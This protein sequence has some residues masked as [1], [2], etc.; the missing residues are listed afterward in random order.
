MTNS[1]LKD[2]G[3][4][5]SQRFTELRL[6][7]TQ[8][9]SIEFDGCTFKGCDFTETH[10]D[11]CKFIDC[12]FVQCNFSNS[13]LGYSRFSQV[14]F[15]DSKLIGLDWNKADWPSFAIPGAISFEKC[16]LNSCS[17]MG[18]ELSAVQLLECKAREVD[19]REC[20]LTEAN[21]RF[22]DLAYSQFNNTNLAD[23]DFCEAVNYD[24]NVFSNNLKGAKFSRVE[25]VNLLE[26]VGIELFD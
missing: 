21:F 25:A 11:R 7:H 5:I 17:F 18:M 22:T 6:A 15:L 26:S 3:E 24:I 1:E 20:N 13:L 23:A 10:F 14:S 9:S 4:Y 2:G 19:F 16:I 12:H 8:V